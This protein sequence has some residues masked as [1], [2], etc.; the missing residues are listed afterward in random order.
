MTQRGGLRIRTQGSALRTFFFRPD[1]MFGYLCIHQVYIRQS[2]HFA[3]AHG[4]GK[5]ENTLYSCTMSRW[6]VACN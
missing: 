5:V 3:A 6:D 2:R 1:I 4:L